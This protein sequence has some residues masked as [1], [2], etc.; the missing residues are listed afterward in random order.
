MAGDL[1]DLHVALAP[2]VIGYGV[3][4]RALADDPATKRDGNPYAS[5]IGMYA[6]AEYQELAGAA[7]EQLDELF[8]RRGNENRMAAL[9]T[10]FREATRLEIGFWQ[11]GLDAS[12]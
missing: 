10:T 6:G 9:E 8:A 1:L 2:C 7:R 12:D 11:M 5:W 4:G 3:I